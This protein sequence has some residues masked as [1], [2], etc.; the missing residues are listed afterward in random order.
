MTFVRPGRGHRI[1][2]PE[3]SGHRTQRRASRPFRLPRGWADPAPA[4]SDLPLLGTPTG[5]AAR[6]SCLSS[7]CR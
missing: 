2:P 7:L 4:G 3:R 6:W 1:S 5:V